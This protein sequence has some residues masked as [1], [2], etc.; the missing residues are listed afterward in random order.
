VAVLRVARR[1]SHKV[2][3]EGEQEV[4]FTAVR[5]GAVL[6]NALPFVRDVVQPPVEDGHAHFAVGP[7]V[8]L[9]ADRLEGV[10]V[11]AV[12]VH[13]D[14]LLEAVGAEPLG[15]LADVF[16]EGA[17]LYGDVALLLAGAMTR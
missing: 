2:G 13:K 6:H 7:L 1:H 14:E 11:A 4:R 17:G 10:Y 5:V 3:L 9:A 16:R 12:G 15:Y 8:H